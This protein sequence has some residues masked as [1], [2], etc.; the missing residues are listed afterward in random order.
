V[1]QNS[2]FGFQGPKKAIEGRIDEMLEMVDLTNKAD[3]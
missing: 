2:I 3:R 1:Q